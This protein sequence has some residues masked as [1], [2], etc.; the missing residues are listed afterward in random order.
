MEVLIIKLFKMR[1]SLP[2]IGWQVTRVYES[3]IIGCG[4]VGMYGLNKAV[5]RD[6]PEG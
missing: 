5:L 4:V 2:E 6:N 3:R 1:S